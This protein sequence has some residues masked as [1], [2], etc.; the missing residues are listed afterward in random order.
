MGPYDEHWTSLLEAI[1]AGGQVHGLG[2]DYAWVPA[3]S[4][5]L[6][7]DP[8]AWG[9]LKVLGG[10]DLVGEGTVLDPTSPIMRGEASAE[11][12]SADLASVAAAL[13]GRSHHAS[14][15]VPGGLLDAGGTTSSSVTDSPGVFDP[16]GNGSMGEDM[17]AHDMFDTGGHQSAGVD[18][19]Q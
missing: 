16:S 18:R 2:P 19:R 11:A 15:A 17:V 13:D 12:W 5:G 1:A 14:P 3:N 8:A 9:G 6:R 7:D 10:D 4:A